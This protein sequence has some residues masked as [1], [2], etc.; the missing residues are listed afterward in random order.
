MNA[1][2][3]SLFRSLLA[4]IR[5]LPGS[6][7]VLLEQVVRELTDRLA[8]E[9]Q[10]QE[11][12]IPTEKVALSPWQERRAKELMSSQMD[13]GLSIAQVASECSLSRS[14]FSRA[15]KKN[16]GLSPRDWYLQMRLDKAKGLLGESGLTISQISLDCGFAD[17]SHFTR[18]FTRVV[19]VTP[20][21]WRRSMAQAVVCRAG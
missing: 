18:V 7:Q 1:F 8:A 5:A 21:N 6:E 14:H 17:Q 10:K 13:K 11:I 4:S 2:N 19:G 20:F 9:E 3:P 15:F 12:E 16:T